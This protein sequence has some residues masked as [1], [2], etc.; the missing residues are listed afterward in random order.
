MD[1]FFKL[2]N[3]LIEINETDRTL[4]ASLLKP[5][6]IEKGTILLKQGDMEKSVAFIENGIFRHYSIVQDGKKIITS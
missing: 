5:K 3:S 1:S 6:E 4:I 2:M